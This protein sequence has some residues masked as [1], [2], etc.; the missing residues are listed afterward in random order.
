MIDIIKALRGKLLKMS[1]GLTTHTTM[2]YDS[3]IR[4]IDAF[5]D[6]LQ[7]RIDKENKETR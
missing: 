3:A 6:E 7:Y 1:L 4:E 2:S 5:L